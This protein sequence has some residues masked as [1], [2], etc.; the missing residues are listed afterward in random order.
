MKKIG[1]I[2]SGIYS[3]VAYSSNNYSAG[4][5]TWTG[6]RGVVGIDFNSITE[7][8]IKSY[9]F[10]T[11]QK[12]FAGGVHYILLKNSSG[13]YGAIEFNVARTNASN[14]TITAKY[15]VFNSSRETGNLQSVTYT[16]GSYMMGQALIN[17]KPFGNDDAASL[18]WDGTS[19]VMYV[20]TSGNNMTGH[21]LY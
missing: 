6:Y 1:L 4:T 14:G 15:V 10:D 7:N 9:T 11:V 5:T 21:W 20:A 16:T 17:W 18:M 19:I 13:K 12:D 2:P 8:Q 3:G